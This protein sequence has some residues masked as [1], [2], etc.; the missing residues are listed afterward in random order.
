M[1]LSEEQVAYQSQMAFD[2]PPRM[3]KLLVIAG[4][5][6]IVVIVMEGLITG[7]PGKVELDKL[8]HFTGYTIVSLV[9][10][11]GLRPLYM[12]PALLG[13]VGIGVA[14]EYVQAMFG[15]S[16]E[17]SDMVANALG[18]AFGLF[19]GISIR[20]VYNFIRREL[21]YTHIRNNLLRF[22][23]GDQVLRQGDQ[24]DKFYLIRKGK[25]SVYRTVDGQ[26]DF[27]NHAEAGDTVGALGL[28]L[29]HEQY[30]DIEADEET[31]IYGLGLGELM[32]SA[33][34]HEQPVS[35]ILK[36]AAEYIVQLNEELMQLKREKH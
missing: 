8:V 36:Q 1:S 25:V 35:I 27:L 28:I 20:L 24:L 6:G 15:R 26:R 7:K 19:L 33:G 23:K 5:V 2:I 11:L 14:A 32:E 21:S 18:T 31:E 17:Y 34:G 9:L 22:N 16:F 4:I 13:I 12:I 3:K 10:V 29:G 30:A